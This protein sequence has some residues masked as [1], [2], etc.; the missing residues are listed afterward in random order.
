MVTNRNPVVRIIVLLLAVLLFLFESNAS[1]NT[2]L[3]I[4]SAI[5]GAHNDHPGYNYRT[6]HALV[7]SYEPDFVGVEI[8]PEDINSGAKYLENNYPREM[9][10]LSLQYGNKAFGF[11]WLGESIEGEK[12]PTGYWNTLR[13]KQLSKAMNND[14]TFLE[15]EPKEL[16]ELIEIQ[17]KI[18]EEATPS[19][20]NNG[21][22]GQICREIDALE[23]EWYGGTQYMEIIEFNRKRDSKIGEN[24]IAFIESHK[25]NRIVLVMGADHR[26]FAIENIRNHFDNSVAILPIS[27]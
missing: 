7:D 25:G 22:Y 14:H 16:A 11:D 18:I 5:H 20:M 12:I 17:S 21:S 26:T 6:L 2:E 10:E 19:S 13:I 9:V 24:V 15:R 8:R 3:V 23:A 27:N 1:E 4:I